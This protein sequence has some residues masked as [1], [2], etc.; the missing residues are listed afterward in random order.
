[1]K[2]CLGGENTL[3]ILLLSIPPITQTS[4]P[5]SQMVKKRPTQ[6]A[7]K[8]ESRGRRKNPLCP[9]CGGNS[10]RILYGP[11]PFEEGEYVLGGC[12]PGPWKWECKEC[13]HRWPKD[14]T[15]PAWLLDTV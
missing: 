8:K 9:I 7:G 2:S 11:P 5:E 13:D 12:E 6:K 14:D 4:P 3:K 1:M 15:E 10:A